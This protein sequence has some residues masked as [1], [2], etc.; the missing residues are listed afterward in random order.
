VS[1]ALAL[2]L[3]LS[4][5]GGDQTR[6]TIVFLTLV[7]IIVTLIVQGA[8][9][10]PLVRWLKAGD[11]EREQRE[12]RHARLKALRAG[13]AVIRGANGTTADFDQAAQQNLIR[14][15][16]EGTRGIA[17]AGVGGTSHPSNRVL[18]Q[19]LDAQRDVVNRLRDA[20]QL[21]G[22]LAERLDTELDLDAMSARGEGKRLTDGGDD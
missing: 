12:E 1:L 5:G 9:L 4:L 19:A 8:T 11:P 16:G 20:G 2:A 21:G 17:V 7:V 14:E 15:I 18:L 6:N 13:I 10:M 3:P 22:E